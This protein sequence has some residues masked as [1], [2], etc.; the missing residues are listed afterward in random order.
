[1]FSVRKRANSPLKT[2]PIS[3]K[4]R[5]KGRKKYEILL[6]INSK[7]S[8]VSWATLLVTAP[9]TLTPT[10]VKTRRIYVYIKYII[11][12]DD[13]AP[14]KLKKKLTEKRVPSI[15][16]AATTLERTTG[17]TSRGLSTVNE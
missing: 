3:A 9:A 7:L 17:R 5:I 8:S 11:T 2:P 14:D 6:F 10:R 13:S 1:M 16:E 12:N 15:I 4:R